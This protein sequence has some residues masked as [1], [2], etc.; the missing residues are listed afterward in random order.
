MRIG[1]ESLATDLAAEVLELL[2]GQPALEIGACVDPRRGVALNEDEVA[3]VILRRRAEEVIEADV[4]ERRGRGEA[5]DV[6]ALRQLALVGVH[7]HRRGVPPHHAAQAP[8]ELGV[9][10]RRLLAVDRDGVDVGGG[11]LE[12]KVQAGAARVLDQRLEQV[13]RALRPLPLEHGVERLDPL[14]RLLRVGIA[15]RID[16]RI[17]GR[18]ARRVAILLALIARAI[19]GALV[20]HGFVEAACGRARRIPVNWNRV[21][22]AQKLR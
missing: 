16:D 10:R 2:L 14:A 1:R 3:T 21:S 8:L 19:R 22:G 5:R 18:I 4:V 11:G 13:V 17:D 6:A 20:V 7:H 12:G 15:R 9:A